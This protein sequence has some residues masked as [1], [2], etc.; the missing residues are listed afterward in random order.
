MSDAAPLRVCHVITGLERGGAETMLAKLCEAHDRARASFTVISLQPGPLAGRIRES[1]VPLLVGALSPS[2][3]P[4]PRAALAIRAML[5]EARPQ[6]VQGWM[7]HGNIAAVLL[8][9]RGVPVAWNV[10]QTLYDL[11]SER[12][13]TRATI[14]AS[15][16]LSTRAAAIVYNSRVSASQH[17]ALGFH[18]ARRVVIPN[19]FDLARFAPSPA[20]RAALRAEL[21]LPADALLVG[22]VARLHP[23][24]DHAT[25]LA[26]A[27]RV[28]AA[29]PEV[30]FALAGDGV[31]PAALGDAAT[32]P[33][34]AGRLHFLGARD[35]M[36]RVSAAFDVVALT[37]AWGEGFPN[38]L[39]EA[40]ACG[41]PCVATDIGDSAAVVGDAGRLVPPRDPGALAAGLLELLGD[42]SLRARLGA[43]GRARV[44]AHFSMPA[45]ADRYLRLYEAVAQGALPRDTLPT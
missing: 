1:G 38:V 7:Y 5:R 36:E 8:A 43:M 28:L 2:R 19:G 22:H 42:S 21:G 45:V 37:S 24:K 13:L 17:E 30:H 23:M 41:V 11:R 40:L 34:L 25:L 10:R 4:S 9:P 32:S 20:A 29:R 35:G 27:A 16:W 31:T 44:T 6:V 12:P 18:A 15:A 33:A 39:G 26:A 14:R 3:L